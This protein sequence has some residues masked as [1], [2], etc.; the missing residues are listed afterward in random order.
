[1]LRKGELHFLGQVINKDGVRPDLDKVSAINKLD[2]PENAQELQRALGMITYLGKYIPDLSTVAQPLYEL[3][4]SDAVWLWGPA[5]QVA[6][7]RIKELVTMSP[8]LV[9]YDVNKRTAV[10]ADASSYGIGGVLLQLHG[11]DWRPVAY[12]SRQLT[13]A[14]TRYAQIEKECLASVWACERFQTYLYGLPSF[15]LI[16]DHKPLIP[17]M[18]CKDLDNVPLRCQRLLMRL[19]RF[20]PKAE[21]APGKTLVMADLMSRSPQRDTEHSQASLADVEGYVAAVMSSVPASPKKMDSIR[22][23]T[24]ADEQ[25]Q[26]VIRYIQGGWPEHIVQ[27]HTSAREYF[28]VRGELSVSVGLVTRGGRI[29]IPGTMRSEMLD[30]IHKGHLGLNKCWDRANAS[31]WWPG[32]GSQITAKVE[33][34]M[35]CR[36]Q[37]RAQ[38]REPLLPTPLPDRLWKKIGIDLCEHEGE[39]YL[40]IA[41]YYSSFLEILHMPTTTSRQ[42]DRPRSLGTG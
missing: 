4:K 38:N 8:T 13:E 35:Y 26:D 27:T 10:S 36:E 17:L 34:C 37:R 7:D 2:Q 20:N 19:M 14:E 11:D 33:N 28:P 32:M 41:D 9:Y 29:V 15:K 31:V 42:T 16:T 24:T 21:Y 39:D 22:A 40:V 30:C 1:M 5:Q 23:E 3:L 18:N 12:C 6:F 25:L